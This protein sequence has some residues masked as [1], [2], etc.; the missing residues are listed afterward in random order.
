M[1]VTS[2]LA[3]PFR[4]NGYTL[5]LYGSVS[6]RG[7]GND[8]DL[9]AVPAELT[10]TPPEEMEKLMCRLLNAKPV[11]EEPREGLLRNWCRACILSDGRQIDIEYRRSV[12]LDWQGALISSLMKPFWDNGYCIELHG[13]AQEHDGK[14]NDLELLALPVRCVVTVPEQME[15]LMC[16]LFDATP[17]PEEARNGL[18]R[19]WRT[20]CVLRD[21]RRIGVEYRLRDEAA[22]EG[23]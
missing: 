13:S 7:N 8:L 11:P 19:T 1:D 17:V 21:G 23:V 22:P 16:E 15:R 12:P 14:S 2:A 6:Q 5:A 20:A 4:S 18:V 3:K 10:G 9:L